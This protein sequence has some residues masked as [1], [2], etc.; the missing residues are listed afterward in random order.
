MEIPDHIN[1][2]IPWPDFVFEATGADASSTPARQEGSVPGGSAVGLSDVGPSSANSPSTPSTPLAILERYWGYTAFRGIQ[3][4]IIDSILAGHDTLGLMPTGGGK[5]ITFQVPALMLSGTCIVVTPLIALMKD[6]VQHLRQRGIKATCL[7]AGLSHEQILR[8]LDNCILGR[9]TFLYLSP[10]RLHTELFLRKLSKLRVSFVTVD[11]AHCISQWG[12]DFRPSYLK[13]RELRRHLPHA[14][15]L[16]LTATATPAVVDDVCGQLD[17]RPGA[18]VHRMSFAR[19]NLS[20]Q[21]VRTDGKLEAIIHTLAI[22]QD[23]AIVYVRSRSGSRDLA[24][25][26]QQRGITAIYY[27]AGLSA[28]EKDTRQQMWQEG[29]ARVMVATNAFGMGI[30]K[31]DVRLVLHLD[32]P[33][34]LEAYFQEAGRAGRDGQPSVAILFYNDADKRLMARRIAQTFPP[35]EKVRDIYDDLACYF[36]LAVDDGLDVR[37]Q[38]QLD[39]FCRNFHYFPA[40][41]EAALRILQ[42]AGYVDYSDEDDARSRVMFITR[43]DDLYSVRIHNPLADRV[44]GTLLRHYEGLFSDY[45]NI[46]EAYLARECQAT[47]D[48]VYDALLALTRMRILHYIPRKQMPSVTYTQRRVS[49]ER[50]ALPPEV[51]EDRLE[52]YA[53]RIAAVIHYLDDDLTPRSEQLLSYFGE[54]AGEAPATPTASAPPSAT[55]AVGDGDVSNIAVP[56]SVP[57]SP[58]DAALALLSDG[59]LHHPTELQALPF[60]PDAI[61]DALLR[62]LDMGCVTILRGHFTLSDRCQ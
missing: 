30:D 6:Q 2:N 40:T 54:E 33:D 46:D 51:Y 48:E 17:F 23:C 61:N 19:P 57:A 14:P 29:R 43:R 39:D 25:T 49:H 37:Y 4:D 58:L 5:S 12:Y 10:E 27:H 44:M 31:P 56:A 36:Q 55:V 26:L 16:A 32:P 24:L 47:D 15:I 13:I 1:S 7:H 18:Q 59:G 41:V 62:L 42:L 3:H 53:E 45:V 11:E 50:I 9:Y 8:E 52:Q 20:Y 34:S 22:T 35:K 38:L 21:V 60:P 28:A